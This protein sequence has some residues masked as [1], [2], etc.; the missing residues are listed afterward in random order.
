VRPSRVA[1]A[2][3]AALS[4]GQQAG[5]AHDDAADERECA[6]SDIT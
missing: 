3:S 5:G 4:L 6:P 2:N 1:R